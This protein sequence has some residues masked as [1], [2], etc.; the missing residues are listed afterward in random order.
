MVSARPLISKSFSPCTKPLVIVPSAPITISSAVT[1]VFHNFFQ[2][3][4]KVWVFI[5]IIIIIT[6]IIIL[7]S[8]DQRDLEYTDCIFCR[9]LRFSPYQKKKV[10]LIWR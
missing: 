4:S 6:N 9:E 8:L 2:L 10:S 5:S 1:F 3:S 7:I